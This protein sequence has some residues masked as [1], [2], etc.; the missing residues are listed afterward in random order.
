MPSRASRARPRRS[1]FVR[2]RRSQRGGRRASVDLLGDVTEHHD[3]AERRRQRRDQEAVIPPRDHAGNGADRVAAQAVGDEPLARD[4][5][6]GIRGVG[7]RPG[8]AANGFSHGRLVVTRSVALL[9]HRCAADAAWTGASTCALSSEDVPATRSGN[10]SGM[11]P[12]PYRGSS[13]DHATLPV[14]SAG[15]ASSG[16]ANDVLLQVGA[17]I[18]D[19]QPIVIAAAR[20]R[21]A[22]AKAAGRGRRRRRRR[23][24]CRRNACDLAPEREQ[25]AMQRVRLRVRLA[26]R[27]V[28][29]AAR[30]RRRCPTDRR[31]SALFS[32]STML[33]NCVRNSARPF[34][35]ALARSPVEIGEVQKRRGRSRTPGP[36][37]A[38][39][40]AGISSSSAVIARQLAALVR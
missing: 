1:S 11:P 27:E 7:R 2:G 35:T 14:R 4:Q 15:G 5:R 25:I 24:D 18:H 22:A 38:S 26:L 9:G 30:E 6:V 12:P 28:E 13:L 34:A 36:E 29:R 10:M 37:T 33:G 3:A 16:S 40:C 19:E 31:A 32:N 17:E 21:I 20:R 39:A 23:V 8:D